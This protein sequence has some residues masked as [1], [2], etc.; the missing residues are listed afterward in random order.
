MEMKKKNPPASKID[1]AQ[2]G[3]TRGSK[4]GSLASGRS[5]SPFEGYFSPTAV[6]S[7]SFEH[8][9]PRKGSL[10]DALLPG[11]SSATVGLSNTSDPESLRVAST[12]INESDRVKPRPEHLSFAPDP[13]SSLRIDTAP[14]RPRMNPQR[15]MSEYPRYPNQSHAALQNQR[16]PERHYLPYNSS[17]KPTTPHSA[18]H[19]ASALL[20]AAQRDH[21]AGPWASRTAG[22]TPAQTPSL[23]VP[24]VLARHMWAAYDGSAETSPYPSPYLHPVQPQAPKETKVADRGVDTFSGRKIINQY[25]IIEELGRGVHGKVKLARNLDTNE[26]V[27]IKVVQRYTKRRRLGKATNQD[28]KVK[29]EVAILKKVHHPNVVT[30]L[31]VIDDPEISK[32]YVVLEFCELREV[33][34]RI[35]GSSEIVVTENRRLDREAQGLPDNSFGTNNDKFLKAA[36]RRRERYRRQRPRINRALVGDSDFWSLEYA[37]ETD[38]EDDDFPEI[39]VASRTSS[40][41]SR[42]S[43]RRRGEDHDASQLYKVHSTASDSYGTSQTEHGINAQHFNPVPYTDHKQLFTPTYLDTSTASPIAQTKDARRGRQPSVADSIISQITEIMEEEIPEDYRYVP[44]MTL[45]ESRAAFRDAVLGLEYLHYQGI[46]H[47]DIKP[48]NLLRTRD[49]H[50]KISDFGVSYLGKPMREGNDSEEASETESHGIEEEAELAKTVGTPSFYAPELCATDLSSKMPVV[51]GQIDVWALGVTLYCLLFART[52]F[53]AENEFALMRKIAEEDVFIPRKR[54]KAVDQR[55]GSRSNSRSPM[56]PPSGDRRLP[57]EWAH[58]DIDDQLYDLLRRLFIKNPEDRITLT[59]VKYHAWVLQDVGN[60]SAWLDET[61][62]AR[63]THGKKIEIS[64]QEV[65]EAVIPLKPMDR[66]INVARKMMDVF[67]SGM[68]R[69]RTQSSATSSENGSTAALLEPAITGSLGNKRGVRLEDQIQLAFKAAREREHDHPLSHSVSVSPGSEPD[70]YAFENQSQEDEVDPISPARSRPSMPAREDSSQTTS[71]SIMTIRQSDIGRGRTKYLGSS[72][73]AFPENETILGNSGP[74]QLSALFTGSRSR[75]PSLIADRKLSSIV[76]SPDQGRQSSSLS[77]EPSLGMNTASVPGEMHSPTLSKSHPH[78]VESAASSPRADRHVTGGH[79]E[80]FD[81]FTFSPTTLSKAQSSTKDSKWLASLQTRGISGVE[82]PYVQPTS[83]ATDEQY[84]QALETLA[85]RRLLEDE[86]KRERSAQNSRPGSSLGKGACPPS[87]DDDAFMKA[88]QRLESQSHR[89]HQASYA[90]SSPRVS[91]VLPSRFQSVSPPSPSSDEQLTPG[92]SR[93]T[94]FPSEQSANSSV[95]LDLH[96]DENL[97]DHSSSSSGSTVHERAVE[98]PNAAS[99]R[100]RGNAVAIKHDDGYAGEADHEFEAGEEGEASDSEEDFLVMGRGKKSQSQ[101]RS[102][103]T[104]TD[105][106]PAPTDRRGTGPRK[107]GRSGSTNT[108][109]QS[110]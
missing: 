37:E 28:D 58:E 106:A 62:P 39:E 13:G 42:R 33:E 30:L 57:T 85:R 75:D 78:L 92:M 98:H 46:I 49:H 99:G 76:S 22:N 21:G 72:V 83:P 15:S 20:S 41:A 2:A 17:S 90:E 10:Q 81:D 65:A 51:T 63:H 84:R 103:S 89:V 104:T 107:S 5:S 64:N 26:Y 27:A 1:T 3:T 66:A 23:F 80:Y 67:S 38:E 87:P 7:H 6:T 94:S 88:Q 55:P 77:G 11:K 25:E 105:R 45:A 79:A 52:P 101:T 108:M 31:E 48:A 47:R 100:S 43:V 50:V 82:S 60:H 8:G 61:D 14:A 102:R 91:S 18:V 86:H 53:V 74:A 96:S 97:K 70:Q 69:K 93:S 36:A 29:K 9:E 56:F 59:E 12:I 68:G 24:N 16:H 32:I 95:A 4:T 34:W 44:T 19:S 71:A 54:L 40:V 109:K 110:Q 73:G 35:L